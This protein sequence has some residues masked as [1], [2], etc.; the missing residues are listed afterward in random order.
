MVITFLQTVAS[1]RGSFPAG[2]RV[3][4]PALPSTWRAWL[5]S[6]VIAVQS[7]AGTSWREAATADPLEESAVVPT[8]RGRGR[9][10][11]R[12]RGTDPVA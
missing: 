9:G 7:D 11:G 1:D 12:R 6:G 8:G 4:V 5:E 10:R 3:V 2:H